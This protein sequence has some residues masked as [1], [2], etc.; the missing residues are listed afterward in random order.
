MKAK[1]QVEINIPEEYADA[2]EPEL[3]YFV[4]D[5]FLRIPCL[6]H[7]EYRMEALSNTNIDEEMRNELNHFHKKMADMT[8]TDN[9]KVVINFDKN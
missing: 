7:T 6:R 9:M 2:T 8:H 4:Y 1:I 3:L 5:N